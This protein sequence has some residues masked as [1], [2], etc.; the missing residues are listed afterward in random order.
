MAEYF[1]VIGDSC[2]NPLSMGSIKSLVEKQVGG[3]VY[4][5][6]LEIGSNIIEVC[7]ILIYIWTNWIETMTDIAKRLYI[8]DFI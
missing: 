2:C 8:I 6:S 3:G 1:S 5:K 7:C 4:V